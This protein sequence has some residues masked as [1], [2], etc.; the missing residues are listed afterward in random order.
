MPISAVPASDEDRDKALVANDRRQAANDF[1][2][3][4]LAG[5]EIFLQECVF[6]FSRGFDQC[7]AGCFGVCL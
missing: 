6:A 2:G 1:L 7:S 3:G 5:F 4:E